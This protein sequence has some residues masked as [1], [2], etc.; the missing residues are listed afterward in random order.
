MCE[1]I[2]VMCNSEMYQRVKLIRSA[3]KTQYT[4]TKRHATVWFGYNGHRT[5]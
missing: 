5:I 4:V 2:P 3:I 1:I